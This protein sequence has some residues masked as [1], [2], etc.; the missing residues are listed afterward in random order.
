MIEN[1]A[2]N[3]ITLYCDTHQPV[4]NRLVSEFFLQFEGVKEGPKSRI[5]TLYQGFEPQEPTFGYVGRSQQPIKGR[6]M[7]SPTCWIKLCRTVRSSDPCR[8]VVLSEVSHDTGDVGL[9]DFPGLADVIHWNEGE[10]A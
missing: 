3:T 9:Q 5:G 4:S 10:R 1:R 6:V 2:G 8:F 7:L